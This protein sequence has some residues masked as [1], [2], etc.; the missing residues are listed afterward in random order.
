MAQRGGTSLARAGVLLGVASV[1]ATALGYGLTVLLTRAYGPA[2]YGALGAL[3]GVGLIGG[4]PS[5]ALQYVLA[6]RTAG[7][8]LPAGANERAGLRLSVTVGAA[9]GGLVVLLSPVADAFF[10]LG[11]PWPV[12]WL[13][14]TLLP[15]WGP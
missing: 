7:A 2:E 8:G 14:V 4:I 13:G 6:R 10:H 5:G 15:K 1:L 12:I 3:L 11:S 9:L